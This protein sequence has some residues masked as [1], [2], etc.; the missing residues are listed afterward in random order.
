MAALWHPVVRDRAAIG[1]LAIAWREPV[2]GVSLRLSAL[3]DLL[4]AEAAVAIGRADLLGRLEQMARTDDLTALPNR[5][6]W[7]QELPRELARAWREDRKI[8]V[9]FTPKINEWQ[10]RRTI[11]IEVNDFQ[12]GP[13]ARL[14]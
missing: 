14:G 9:A 12:A 6:A 3:I 4:G 7:E 11:E 8:C 10:D 1:V 13:V 2:A 5:R